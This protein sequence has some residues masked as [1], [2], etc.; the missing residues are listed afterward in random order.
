LLQLLLELYVSLGRLKR[1]FLAEEIEENLIEG[2]QEAQQKMQEAQQKQKRA[3]RHEGGTTGHAGGRNSSTDGSDSDSS[4]TVQD[5]RQGASLQEPLLAPQEIGAAE[6]SSIA[7]VGGA[8]GA[9]RIT[10][11]FNRCLEKP[12]AEAG[13]RP[14]VLQIVDADFRWDDRPQEVSVKRTSCVGAL[15]KSV[16]CKKAETDITTITKDGAGGKTKEKEEAAVPLL[17]PA[18]GKEEETEGKEEEEEE[19]EG[20]EEEGASS[21]CTSHPTLENVNFSVKDGGLVCIV[22]SVGAGKSSLLAA[23]LNEIPIVARVDGTGADA[24]SGTR[25]SV[26]VAGSV[27]YCEQKPWVQS[28][29]LRDNILFGLPMDRCRYD[30]T[31]KSCALEHDLEMLANGDL[32]EIGERGLNLSGGQQARVSLA[33]AVYSD[34]D[35]MLLDDVLS[36]VDVHVCA[37]LLRNCILN[38]KSIGTKTRVIAT[39]QL[40]WLRYADRVVVMESGKIKDS[41]TFD[42]LVQRGV[43]ERQEKKNGTEEVKGGIEPVEAGGGTELGKSSEG[44]GDEGDAKDSPTA[45]GAPVHSPKASSGETPEKKGKDKGKLTTSEDRETGVVQLKVWLEYVH[46]LTP[47][48]FAAVLVLVVLRAGFQVAGDMSL[49]YWTQSVRD[50]HSPPQHSTNTS[51]FSTNTSFSSTNTSFSSGS[52]S[53]FSSGS[54]S[55]SSSSGHSA[56]RPAQHYLLI[57]GGLLLSSGVFVYLRAIFMAY[58]SFAASVSLHTKAL[59]AVLRSPMSYFDSTPTGRIIN[60]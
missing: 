24:S 53:S 48:R 28:A 15:R 17:D 38:P 1:F 26:T 36:A 2:L 12:S 33:R 27:A 19:T 42:E 23:L 49:T 4:S 13:V 34:A 51:D 20:K 30:R 58:A 43:M 6:I 10:P 55:S 60:R 9:L 52:S 11:G 44:K 39:H 5:K 59:W 21:M 7:G 47:T 41:G 8:N 32:T 56:Y 35:I 37:H 50:H 46:Q 22:G 40:H 29:T 57:Y 16:C 14:V 31:I 45:L 25:G 3:A 54:S 18:E